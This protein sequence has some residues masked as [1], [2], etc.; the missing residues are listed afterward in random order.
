MS[1]EALLSQLS[2]R[3][4]SGQVKEVVEL[5]QQGI[6]QGVSAQSLLD[7]GLLHG[8]GELSIRF[9]NSE[10]FIAELLQASKAL[11]IGIA[12]IYDQLSFRGS[13]LHG[14]AVIATVEGDL[15]DIGKNLVKLL[16]ESSGMEVIDLGSDVSAAQV[17][18]AVRKSKPDIVALSALLTTTMENQ[19][20]I[21]EALKA[22]GLRDQV[23]VIV[24]G[25]PITAEF[26]RNIGADGYAID[27]AAAV[28]L[29]DKLLPKRTR[30][31]RLTLSS[32]VQPCA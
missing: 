8:L 4:Q 1:A 5:I 29:V 19:L 23:K 27:A 17:V 31:S 20:A 15:H 7:D 12:L 25:A 3:V 13:F 18:D 30:Q 10:I 32:Q 11:K 6:S 22:A 28:E 9:R 26:C 14:K 21:I 24:G 2:N 16:L